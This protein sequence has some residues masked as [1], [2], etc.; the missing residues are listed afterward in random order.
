MLL[1]CHGLLG[2]EDGLKIFVVL[3]ETLLNHSGYLGL[4]D[5]LD[6]FL[7]LSVK[8]TSCHLLIRLF[9]AFFA[10]CIGCQ[11]VYTDLEDSNL[12]GQSF[13]SNRLLYLELEDVLEHLFSGDC[14]FHFNNYIK[15]NFLGYLGFCKSCFES[16]RSFKPLV[17]SLTTLILIK[18]QV[19]IK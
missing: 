9:D 10:L 4:C 8:S 17:S 2:T 1:I 18:K 16:V 3:L 7:K 13:E 19:A 5:S 12:H 15:L 11:R 14:L 6:V